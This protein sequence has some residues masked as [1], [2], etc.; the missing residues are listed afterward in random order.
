VIELTFYITTTWPYRW[1]TIKKGGHTLASFD[2]GAKLRQERVGQG[3]AVE[4][5]ARDTRIPSRFLQ[6]I[7]ADDF[8][9]LPGLVFTRNFVKQYAL[10]L[11]LDPDPLLA[12]L[13][14][15][16]EATVQLPDPPARSR[17][18][19]YRDRASR[20]MISSVAWII[21]A[22]GAGFAAYVHF[23]H[24]LTSST[25][26]SK[27][28]SVSALAHGASGETAIAAPPAVTDTPQSEPTDSS[29]SSSL[30]QNGAQ[31]QDAA[32]LQAGAQSPN[33]LSP[34]RQ[35]GIA[36]SASTS[37]QGM[38]VQ[39][40]MTAQEPAW[41]QITVDGKTTF[42]GTMHSNETKQIAAAEQVR[43]L[44]GNAGGL[45]IS[46][47]GKTLEPLGP[48]GQ[49]RSVKLTAEGPQ[50][51]SKVPRPAPPDPL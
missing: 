27:S 1:Y 39:V 21:V 6:A 44:T 10:A 19:Y 51:L 33:E 29:S 49:I 28:S 18:S 12:E 9:R 22:G 43:V 34:P 24:T 42:T 36:P 14:K 32:Q 40:S 15:Q 41:V 50:L 3:L 38:P 48:T 2:I 4:D 11:K 25:L 23:N 37:A 45:T 8:T 7:E 35:D 46:L 5:I 17:S 13:P 30:P 16:D 26:D 31:L 20:S 47:N